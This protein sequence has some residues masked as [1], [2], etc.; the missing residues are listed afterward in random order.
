MFYVDADGPDGTA[1][2][3]R[4]KHFLGNIRRMSERAARREHV[5]IMDGVNLKPGSTAPV[6][7]GQTFADAVN[8]WRRAIAPNLS[9]ATVRPRESFLRAHILPR[10]GR[11]G[12]NEMGVDEIQ[13]FATDLRRTL[14]GK[15]NAGNHGHQLRN[16]RLFYR[17]T[18]EPSQTQPAS[19]AAILRLAQN[20][21]EESATTRG[22]IQEPGFC[23]ALRADLTEISILAPIARHGSPD[24]RSLETWKSLRVSVR[25]AVL[26]SADGS[27]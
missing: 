18:F 16:N 5:R 22:K 6:Y 8:T 7:K 12:L 10:F 24:A 25:P 21:A 11:S 27:F 3:K 15:K 20:A 2:S 14:S 9:P 26:P 17:F 19:F 23:H 4:V 1:T 13:Q